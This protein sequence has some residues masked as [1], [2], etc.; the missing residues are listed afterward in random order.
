[1]KYLKY[2]V[3]AC[4]YV[5]FKVHYSYIL[6]KDLNAKIW[7]WCIV[8]VQAYP[9]VRGTGG[10][11]FLCHRGFLGAV[12]VA[13]RKLWMYLLAVSGIITDKVKKYDKSLKVS[14]LKKALSLPRYITEPG[15]KMG[16]G[17]YFYIYL[18]EAYCSLDTQTQ[19]YQ[20]SVQKLICTPSSL[21][22]SHRR[23]SIVMTTLLLWLQCMGCWTFLS[24]FLSC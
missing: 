7:F 6:L 14:S 21:T 19:L 22:I 3:C 9:A 24:L 20:C 23:Q 2:T 16:R 18:M 5:H 15:P 8:F 11:E 1:M 12:I 10:V 17:I 13:L 4:L